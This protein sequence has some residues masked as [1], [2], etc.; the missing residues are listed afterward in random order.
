[1]E[2]L[3]RSGKNVGRFRSKC[4]DFKYLAK[5]LK[6]FGF[7]CTE[8]R[9][10]ISFSKTNMADFIGREACRNFSTAGGTWRANTPQVVLPSLL[11]R[12]GWSL[13]QPSAQ[14]YLD[15]RHQA[16]ECSQW[17]K[18]LYRG[19]PMAKLKGKV[20]PN[21]AVMQRPTFASGRDARIEA[22]AAI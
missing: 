10:S 13:I 11:F 15:G 8:L 20:N 3:G 12:Q 16:S 5:Y 22:G 7:D 9:S 18:A 1:V 4:P 2:K 6:T 21:A 19:M 14:E 17:A